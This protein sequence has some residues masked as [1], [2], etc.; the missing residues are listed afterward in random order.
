MVL[1][2]IWKKKEKYAGI[3]ALKKRIFFFVYGNRNTLDD[4]KHMRSLQ[5][6]GESV[7]L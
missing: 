5:Y 6:T 1:L 7:S 3:S 2:T 4:N